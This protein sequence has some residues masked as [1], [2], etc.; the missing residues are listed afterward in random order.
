MHFATTAL[1][2]GVSVQAVLSL[3][4]I[5][6]HPELAKIIGFDRATLCA[7]KSKAAPRLLAGGYAELERELRGLAKAGKL[8]TVDID[9][10]EEAVVEAARESENSIVQ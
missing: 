10:F 3:P 1:P 4:G 8:G 7:P 6:D 5:L 2:N 9:A